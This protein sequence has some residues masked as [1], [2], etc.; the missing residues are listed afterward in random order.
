MPR[1]SSIIED[2]DAPERNLWD[3]LEWLYIASNEQKVI[4]RMQELETLEFKERKNWEEHL[5]KFHD[6]LSKFLLLEKNTTEEK[7][8]SKLKRNL[9]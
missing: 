7:K 4:N 2:N 5:K 3:A 9:P 8:K 1:T 6:T